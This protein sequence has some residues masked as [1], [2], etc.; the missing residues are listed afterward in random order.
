MSQKLVSLELAAVV[1]PMVRMWA[2]LELLPAVARTV[3]PPALPR[4]MAASPTPPVPAWTSIC[5]WKDTQRAEPVTWAR[6]AS[7]ER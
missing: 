6:D 5:S 1:T 4:W 7:G 3:L 2:R